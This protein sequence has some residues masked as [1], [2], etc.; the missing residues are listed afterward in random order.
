MVDIAN[1]IN[2]L[3]DATDQYLVMRGINRKKY[4]PA[5]LIAARWAW[6]FL[7]KNT[8]YSVNSQWVTLKKGEPYNY[9]DLPPNMV[10]LFSI[11]TVDK[12]CNKVVPLF[13]NNTINIL[14]KP[15][16]SQKKCGCGA[17]CD[18]GGLC[19]NANSLT[20]T[21][22][23]LFSINGVDYIEKK[24]VK[25]C[26]NGDILEYTITPVK[27]YNTFAGDPGDYNT[28]YM[29]D[30][31]IGH[32]P[33]ADYTIEYIESQKVICKLDVAP[34]GCPV[35]SDENEQKLNEF[36][37]CFMPFNSCCKKKHCNSFLGEINNNCKGEVK[38]SECGTKAYFIP[39]KGEH[40]LP[41]FLLVNW[42]TSGETCD[43]I[44]Y[45]PEYAM[46]T[47]F[48][49][50][51][52]YSIRYNNSYSLNEKD[53]ARYQWQDQQNSLLMYLNPISLEWLSN[54]QDAKIKY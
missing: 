38:V 30:F 4:Y 35:E 52:Y 16:E 5:Y 29:N 10:R 6:K 22:K 15:S 13:Y 31:D 21:T 40:G 3:A 33:F 27:K 54:V 47:L 20:Y 42:Q 44:V 48:A 2:T 41:D 7:F 1:D 17:A 19:E 45:V 11:A 23:V 25:V 12:H 14:K 34:C 36:C 50:I 37:G 51:N 9:I 53:H 26:P 43:E 46:E 39:H 8:I 24:W 18:C 49:G 28:D 32:P